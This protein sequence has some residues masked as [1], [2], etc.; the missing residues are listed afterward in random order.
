MFELI[1]EF[2]SFYASVHF[3]R[4]TWYPSPHVNMILNMCFQL[5]ESMVV[6]VPYHTIPYQNGRVLVP[7]LQCILSILS[8]CLTVSRV[9]K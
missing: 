4:N 1:V 6:L 8:M 9:K 2:R 5:V 3:F 7:Y